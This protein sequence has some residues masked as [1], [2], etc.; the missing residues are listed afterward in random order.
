MFIVDEQGADR[1]KS[2]LFAQRL[3]DDELMSEVFACSSD[4]FPLL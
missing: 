1:K 2:P 4:V 3:R